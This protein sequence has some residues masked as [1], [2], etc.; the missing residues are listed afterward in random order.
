[1]G[2][3]KR[4]FLCGCIVGGALPLFAQAENVAYGDIVFRAGDESIQHWLLP[5]RPPYPSDNK[6]TKERVALGKQLFF[7][8]RLSGDSNMSCATCHNPSLGWG[9][10]LATSRGAKSEMLAR[11][12]PTIFN[13]GYNSIQM[14]DGRK[15][16][17]EDQ[18]LGPITSEQEMNMDITKLMDF[19]V[20][21]HG[22]K[23]AFAEA[24]PGESITTELVA[25][26]LASYERTIIS[27]DSDFDRWVQGDR[28]AMTKQQVN[29][30]KLFINPDKGNCSVCHSAPNF[31][32]NGFHNLGLA[33]FGE[34]NPDVGRY[35]EKPIRLMKG[36]FKTPTLREITR[37]A[38]YFHDGSA[39]TLEAVMAHYISG[40][41][42]KSNL[43][44]NLK[45]LTLT[46]Q[47]SNDVVA[48]LSALAS[49]ARDVTLP[50]LP[51]N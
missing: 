43:S 31:T 9:D 19:L 5:A 20:G 28:S 26:A 48:F 30:F 25:K 12:T 17:L 24:F 21:N 3:I 34:E 35:A 27:R 23:V 51:L 2:F 15:K 10:A 44:P 13:T 6:P 29:G 11:A 39:A 8:P 50:Q 41:V 46:E 14:W 37:T 1:M 38:P 42:V 33:S 22:Y 36:A 45:A 4:V 7:D 49:P 47:E 32:D 16:T 40:G 18:A